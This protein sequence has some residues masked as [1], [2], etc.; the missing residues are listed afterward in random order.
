MANDMPEKH[1]VAG[2]DERSRGFSRAVD[3]EHGGDVFRAIF[4]YET[5]VL[6][7]SGAGS[8]DA[9][10]EMIRVL[11]ERGYSQLRTRL[12]FCDGAYLGSQEPWVE[13]ADPQ[14]SPAA[15]GGLFG[16]V[17]RIRQAL[18]RRSRAAS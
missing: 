8:S 3:I 2:L 12:L 14:S 5:F 18:T 9:L 1:L 15:S 16:L 6:E 17:R 11:Q 10:A 7:S 4:R 13:Y